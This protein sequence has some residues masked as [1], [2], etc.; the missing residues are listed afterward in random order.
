M[1]IA[2]I[3]LNAKH[4]IKKSNDSREGFLTDH[5]VYKNTA[6]AAL[7][8]HKVYAQGYLY[9]G[10]VLN[11]VV[12]GCGGSGKNRYYIRPNIEVSDGSS[13]FLVTDDEE[14][15]QTAR[16]AYGDRCHVIDFTVIDFAD[17]PRFS[18]NG[19]DLLSFVGSD[20]PQ[21]LVVRTSSLC[22]AYYPLVSVF[23]MQALQ[24]LIKRPKVT[25]CHVKVILDE[26]QRFYIPELHRYMARSRPHNFSIDTIWQSLMQMHS[27][28]GKATD[29]MLACSSLVTL[30]V[31]R[32]KIPFEA[33]YYEACHPDL[34]LNA[35]K[36]VFYDPEKCLV[37]ARGKKPYLGRKVGCNATKR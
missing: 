19:Y 23:V 9:D 36:D 15:I 11:T 37:L 28:Y 16:K 6:R 4:L 22:T 34:T 8:T 18:K 7:H 10:P 5:E 25:G 2:E 3:I 33:S 35:S 12:T 21:A 30:G 20:V 13:L 14:N 24:A 26:A 17:D 1:K 27:V 32:D 31:L 29:R